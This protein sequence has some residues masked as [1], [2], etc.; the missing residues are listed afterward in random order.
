M[1]LKNWRYRLGLVI[2]IILFWTIVIILCM[3]KPKPGFTKYVFL[4]DSAHRFV[5]QYCN[6]EEITYG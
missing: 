2:G 4:E 6:I 3:P 5:E 1:E